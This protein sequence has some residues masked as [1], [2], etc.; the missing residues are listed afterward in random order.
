MTPQDLANDLDKRQPNWL[1]L[2][3]TQQ[4]LRDF[5]EHVMNQHR[6]VD[7]FRAATETLRREVST[8]LLAIYRNALGKDPFQ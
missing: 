1:T 8:S 7:R 3:A 2:F 5:A 6:G 4:Q